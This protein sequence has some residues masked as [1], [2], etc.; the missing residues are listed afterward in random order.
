MVGFFYTQPTSMLA[1]VLRR[2]IQARL[3]MAL[4]NLVIDLL[5]FVVDPR[6]RVGQTG[7]H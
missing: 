3:A 7:G 6:L 5:C 1:F 4:I 2:L